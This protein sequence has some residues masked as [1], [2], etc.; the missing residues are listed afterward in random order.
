MIEP[1]IASHLSSVLS[2]VY[3]AMFVLSSLIALFYFIICKK[4]W[5]S[6]VN[7][8]IAF[9]AVPMIMTIINKGNLIVAMKLLLGM[10]VF[11]LMIGYSIERGKFKALNVLANIFGA[12]IVLNFITVVLFPD[13]IYTYRTE[14]TSAAVYFLGHRN[15]MIK[16]A[17]PA[18]CF[19]GA[20]DMLCDGKVRIRSI[21]LVAAT[22]ISVFLTVSTTGMIVSVLFCIAYLLWRKKS[23]LIYW[24]VNNYAVIAINLGFFVFIVV[25]G[26]QR[27]FERFISDFLGKSLTFTG[28]TLL[29]SRILV[30][31]VQKP[32]LGYGILNTSEMTAILSYS[33]VSAHNL[34]ADFLMR[35]GIVTVAI[36]IVLLIIIQK[37]MNRVPYSKFRYYI[38]CCIFACSI[39]W[40]TDTYIADFFALSWAI[41][42]IG[43]YCGICEKK[44]SIVTKMKKGNSIVFRQGI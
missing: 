5:A 14:Y 22:V 24:L 29:W 41:M 17:I 40:L 13:G 11:S 26:Y 44:A 38:Q 35:G 2:Q 34:I 39:G 8:G 37:R 42:C 20:Y 10:L 7:Y 32:F 28:R 3:S 4:Y 1:Y 9:Y 36:L 6:F 25:L 31:I 27:I 43:Y 16:F 15:S 30:H 23:R 12:Y 18:I 19:S 33:N 21:V